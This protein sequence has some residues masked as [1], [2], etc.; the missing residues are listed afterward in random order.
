ML[1]WVRVAAS[2][3]PW[4]ARNRMIA[5]HIP[6]GTRV[7]EFG[8]GAQWLRRHA[9]LG[10]YHPV[11]CVPGEGDVFLCDYNRDARFPDVSA[12]LVVMSG[13]LEYIINIEVFLESLGAAYPGL[14]CVFG[15]AFEPYAPSKRAEHGWIARVNP[16]SEAETPFARI[17]KDLKVLDVYV[18]SHTR[19]VIYEGVL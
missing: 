8:S 1:H 6:P 16:A 11:D 17:F 4:D 14:R 13:F 7:I 3:P 19:Q 9:S 18:T 5:K 12:D 2:A 10:A 15:W